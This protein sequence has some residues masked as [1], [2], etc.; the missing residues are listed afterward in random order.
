MTCLDQL[1]VA[2]RRPTCTFSRLC[3]PRLCAFITSKRSLWLHHFLFLKEPTDLGRNLPTAVTCYNAQ[4]KRLLH[5][6]S[7]R[8]GFHTGQ[9]VGDGTE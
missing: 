4:P 1:I 6:L 7:Q 3:F 8:R 5:F 2:E 9:D